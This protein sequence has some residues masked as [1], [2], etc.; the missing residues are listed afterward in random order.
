MIKL[1]NIPEELKRHAGWLGWKFTQKDKNKKPL[2]MPHYLKSGKWRAGHAHG[3]REDRQQLVDFTKAEEIYRGS[4]KKYTG[5]GFAMLADWNCTAADFDDC[6][7]AEG[8][9]HPQVLDL[10]GPT[11]WEISPSGNGIRAFFSGPLRDVK[12]ITQRAKKKGL[13]F[14]VEFFCSKGFVTVTG[15]VTEAN[16]IIGQ[17]IVPITP[18]LR[19]FFEEHF[20][21]RDVSTR[22]SDQPVVGMTDAEIVKML[23]LWDPDCDYD[24]WLKIGMAIH[25][26]TDGAGFELWHDWS[27][28]GASYESHEDC[29]Y[30]WESFGRGDRK[31]V[32]TIRWM[33]HEKPLDFAL[34]NV[35]NDFA[36]LAKKVDA[37]GNVRRSMPR[38]FNIK[39]NGE[40]LASA[41]NVSAILERPDV[42]ESE[43]RSEVSHPRHPIPFWYY[44]F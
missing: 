21:G 29:Q 41:R 28:N 33:I 3:S 18:E 36:P 6:I 8:V 26:E 2:K 7:D 34:E 14:G 35:G 23:E 16:E 25:H 10:V 9:I 5:L 37:D 44:L 19:A 22:N 1:E 40:V 11:Y 42:S 27:A 4:G 39:D 31:S 17:Q 32:K 30:K 43:F 38:L 13:D 15:N 12:L 20:G 24:T